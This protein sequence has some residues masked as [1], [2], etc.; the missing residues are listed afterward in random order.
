MTG[1]Q[2]H[3]VQARLDDE[4]AETKLADKLFSAS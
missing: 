2:S 1:K 3:A 4:F